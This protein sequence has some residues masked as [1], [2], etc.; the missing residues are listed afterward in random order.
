[1]RN[2]HYRFKQNIS[3]V[4]NVYSVSTFSIKIKSNDKC[5]EVDIRKMLNRNEL[6][7]VGVDDVKP[8]E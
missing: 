7:S 6:L 2:K 4:L 3:E 1:M 8:M 5:Y